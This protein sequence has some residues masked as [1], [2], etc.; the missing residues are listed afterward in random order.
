MEAFNDGNGP[1]VAGNVHVVA[2]DYNGTLLADS[3]EPGRIGT[4]I[5]TTTDPF[6]IP[7]VTRLAETARFSIG[8]VSHDGPG[9]GNDSAAGPGLMVVEDVDGAYYVAAGF[10]AAEGDVFPSLVMNTTGEKADRG[11]LAAFVKGA[12]AYTRENG[13]EKAVAAFNDPVGGVAR[14]ELAVMALD[15]NGTALASLP[16]APGWR[17]TGSTC[18]A[19]TTP[20][21]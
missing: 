9:P 5:S 2:V 13:K 14:G 8:L 1:F 3:A 15:C 11:D 12:V 6:G 19:T 10:S 7:L 21:S 16:Y 20:T 18:S 17:R 4:N